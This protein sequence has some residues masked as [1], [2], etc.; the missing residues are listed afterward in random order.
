MWCWHS[1]I[2]SIDVPPFILY[3]VMCGQTSSYRSFLIIF[4]FYPKGSGCSAGSSVL[5][6]TTCSY[7]TRGF[8]PS[9]HKPLVLDFSVRVSTYSINRD[10]STNFVQEYVSIVCSSGS[11]IGHIFVFMVAIIYFKH[12]I[13]KFD[14][15]ILY[16]FVLIYAWG[17]HFITEMCR[18]VRVYEW[19]VILYKLCVFVGV[20]WVIL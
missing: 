16:P 6:Y 20:L 15:L 18:R 1:W 13:W 10:T 5:E 12:C 14:V 8:D 4:Y 9:G 17:W 2:Q 19:F 11:S 3:V 7:M